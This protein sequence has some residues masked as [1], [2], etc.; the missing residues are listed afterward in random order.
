MALVTGDECGL[1]KLADLHRNTATRIDEHEVQAR[2]RGILKIAT[3]AVDATT[4]A[5]TF[6]AA[7]RD[8]ARDVAPVRD[9]RALLSTKYGG[10]PRAVDDLPHSY[11]EGP[12]DVLCTRQSAAHVHLKGGRAT[13]GPGTWR[14]VRTTTTW[15]AAVSS[16]IHYFVGGR[17]CEL[18]RWDLETRE[19]SWKVFEP[20]SSLRVV[21]R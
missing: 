11:R 7:R 19:P 3:S 14:R 20:A 6:H 12:L 13:S 9:G 5:T 21:A 18:T 10:G 1:L 4:G 8:G 16:M 2:S 15:P 17:E